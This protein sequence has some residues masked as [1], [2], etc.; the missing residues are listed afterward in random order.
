MHAD[1]IVVH[2]WAPL[3]AASK[4]VIS[5]AASKLVIPSAASQLAILSAALDDAGFNVTNG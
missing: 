1:S 4:L 3:A 2:G 5:S